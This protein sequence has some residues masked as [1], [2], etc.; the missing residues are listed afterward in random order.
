MLPVFAL[1]VFS[2]CDD[3][4]KP[5]PETGCGMEL[6][7]VETRPGGDT[8]LIDIVPLS[9]ENMLWQ[10]S[11]ILWGNNTF[12]KRYVKDGVTSE[13]GGTYAY[14]TIDGVSYLELTYTNAKNPLIE[15]CTTAEGKEHIQVFSAT[16]LHGIWNQC[17]GPTLVYNKRPYHCED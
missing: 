4:A 11:I 8:N 3:D 16:E 2:S 1:G 13:E 10:E 7:M 6:K 17:D 15:S 9:G 5:D 14:V 12:I